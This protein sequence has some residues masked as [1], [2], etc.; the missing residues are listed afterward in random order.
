MHAL[1]KAALKF[2]SRILTMLTMQI[3]S[4]KTAQ[5]FANA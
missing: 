1:D 3:W 2:T 5:N 4:Q